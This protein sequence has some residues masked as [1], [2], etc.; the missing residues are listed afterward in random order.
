ML[1]IIRGRLEIIDI[2]ISSI[3]VNALVA[4]KRKVLNHSWNKIKT[5][6]ILKCHQLLSQNSLNNNKMILVEIIASICHH[7]NKD[8]SFLI[9]WSV[10]VMIHLNSWLIK[11]DKV[12]P[13]KRGT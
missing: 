2:N 12:N 4:Q 6:F 10:M 11:L 9:S 5:K 8:K 1:N 3:Q 13:K 7:I